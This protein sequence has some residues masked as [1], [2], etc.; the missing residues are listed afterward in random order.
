MDI[1]RLILCF[2]KA[3]PRVFFTIIFIPASNPLWAVNFHSS[4]NCSFWTRPPVFY[5]NAI[6][7]P[8]IVSLLFLW[9]WSITSKTKCSAPQCCLY[10]LFTL[11]FLLCCT[12][13]V[14]NT[15]T[16]AIQRHAIFSRIKDYKTWIIK[17]YKL[18]ICWIK[19]RARCLFNDVLSSASDMLECGWTFCIDVKQIDRRIDINLYI[20]FY[21]LIYF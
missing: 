3:K 4:A 2:F 10:G 14:K 20:T 18:I 13:L 8:L 7:G 16:I 15:V 9:D 17:S 11:F 1:L 21:T 12:V 6:W 5:R 19:C